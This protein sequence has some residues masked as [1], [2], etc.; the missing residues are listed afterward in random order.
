VG[1]EWGE[2]VTPRAAA[3][4]HRRGYTSLWRTLL[5]VSASRPHRS[6]PAHRRWNPEF[7][8]LFAVGY[9]SY[10]FMKQVRP[11]RRSV[12]VVV[13]GGCGFRQV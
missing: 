10:D 11:R 9:G 13:C 3:S 1:G 2:G 7:S 4:V 6:L 5:T 12:S 8:D